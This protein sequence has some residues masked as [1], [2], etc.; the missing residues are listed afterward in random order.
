MNDEEV[1]EMLCKLSVG[2]ILISL[3]AIAVA[4]IKY[5]GG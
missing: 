1:A 2:I 4:L 5:V 3:V